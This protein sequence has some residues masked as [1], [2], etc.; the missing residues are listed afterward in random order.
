MTDVFRR[1]GRSTASSSSTQSTHSI[2][3]VCHLVGVSGGARN[4][5]YQE[6]IHINVGS[7]TPPECI[8]I[9]RKGQT[10]SEATKRVPGALVAKQDCTVSYYAGLENGCQ[11]HVIYLSFLCHF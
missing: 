5:K 6:T 7:H 1:E 11:K 2:G 4:S 9:L 10:N 8:S 3:L